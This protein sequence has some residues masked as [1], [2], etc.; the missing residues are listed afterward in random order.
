MGSRRPLA[1]AG[2]SL[3]AVL[4]GPWP[5]AAHDVIMTLS[6][7]AATEAWRLLGHLKETLGHPRRA[8]WAVRSRRCRQCLCFMRKMLAAVSRVLSGA[9][10]KPVR[11]PG[12]PG[13]GAS[14]AEAGPEGG[15]GRATQS[16]V[17]GARGAGEPLLRPHALLSVPGL[18]RSDADRDPAKVPVDFPLLD[19]PLPPPGPAVRRAKSLCSRG[20]CWFTGLGKGDLGLL[21]VSD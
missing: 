4:V 20:A 13:W 9:S 12:R 17:E 3:D 11:P 2:H 16:G 15:P 10:Q 6:R 19:T 18:S 21:R 14:G 1:G 7:R 8:S 5:G